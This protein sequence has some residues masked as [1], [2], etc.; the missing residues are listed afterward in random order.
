MFHFSKVSWPKLELQKNQFGE[1]GGA[2]NIDQFFSSSSHFIL[3][4]LPKWKCFPKIPFLIAIK[5]PAMLSHL[6]NF[7]LS[8]IFSG[9]FMRENIF[10]WFSLL[11][12]YWFHSSD[13]RENKNSDKREIFLLRRKCLFYS[14]HSCLTFIIVAIV[15]V[16]TF[17]GNYE[18]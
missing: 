5:H 1:K 8:M 4:F 15:K 12:F 14:E 2:K 6:K 9:V 10:T 17:L 16:Q 13:I 18:E 3:L 7:H 11:L